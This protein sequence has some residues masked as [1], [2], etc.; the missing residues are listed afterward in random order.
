[1]RLL[2]I[3]CTAAFAAFGQT[4][5]HISN[6]KQLTNG[7][8][9]AEAYWSPNGKRIV[10]QSDRGG[11]WIGYGSGA[12]SASCPSSSHCHMDHPPTPLKG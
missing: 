9:N 6:I 7:G 4:S 11:K 2:V 8:Q 3:F 1:M 10:F 12:A 5:S